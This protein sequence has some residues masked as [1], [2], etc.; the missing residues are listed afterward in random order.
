MNINNVLNYFFNIRDLFLRVSDYM[1]VLLSGRWSQ[2]VIWQLF[3]TLHHCSWNEL[4]NA[5]SY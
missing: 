2:M 5:Y 1:T 3:C 4:W